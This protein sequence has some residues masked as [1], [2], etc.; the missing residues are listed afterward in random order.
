MEKFITDH[1]GNLKFA[2]YCR[3][4]KGEIQCREDAYFSSDN[5]ILIF[6]QVLSS[7]SPILV[8]VYTEYSSVILFPFA[9]QGHLGIS[10][11]SWLVQHIAVTV[12]RLCFCLGKCSDFNRVGFTLIY[13][14]IKILKL[15]FYSPL[16]H[17][18]DSPAYSSLWMRF[19][20]NT[21]I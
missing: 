11:Y 1:G 2:A 10:F 4:K 7:C 16:R 12:C 15:P 9:V 3:L 19:S 21:T 13:F 8:V 5:L 17:L 20:F 14:K 18:V 6:T